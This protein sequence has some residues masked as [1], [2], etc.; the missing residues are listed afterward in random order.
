MNEERIGLVIAASDQASPTIRTVTNNINNVGRG[1]TAAGN[2]TSTAFQ[3]IAKTSMLAAAKVGM[4]AYALQKVLD[5]GLKAEKI[6]GVEKVLSM[7]EDWGHYN[8]QLEKT[9]NSLDGLV[10]RQDL[11]IPLSKSISLGMDMTGDSFSDLA[12]LVKKASL[13]MGTDYTQALNDAVE[14]MGKMSMEVINNLGVTLSVTE[15][16]ETYAKSIGRTAASLTNAEKKTAFQTVAIKKL[17]EQYDKID[18]TKVNSDLE[19]F[20]KK[21][22]DIK[23]TGGGWVAKAGTFWIKTIESAAEGVAK[24]VHPELVDDLTFKGEEAYDKLTELDKN[25]KKTLDDRYA[26]MTSSDAD[27]QVRWYNKKPM[28]DMAIERI[29]MIETQQKAWTVEAQKT[30]DAL[31]SV[32]GKSINIAE[33]MS[34]EIKD[35]GL[36]GTRVG[37]PY[38]S[39]LKAHLEKNKGRGVNIEADLERKRLAEQ[40][41]RY[42]EEVALASEKYETMKHYSHLYTEEEIREAKRSLD[43]AIEKD[44][45]KKRQLQVT[46]DVEKRELDVE[47]RELDAN[48]A[49]KKDLK[50]AEVDFEK[51]MN[52]LRLQNIK[53]YSK[54]EIDE[55]DY[56]NK[57]KLQKEKETQRQKM[58]LAQEGARFGLDMIDALISGEEDAIPKLLLMAGKS[59]GGQMIMDGIRIAMTGK[60][61]GFLG[62]PFGWSAA[63]LGAAMITT[64]T[65]MYTGASLGLNALNGGGSSGS[66]A[67]TAARENNNIGGSKDINVNVNANL[68]GSK[69]EAQLALKKMGVSVNY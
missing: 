6:R 31:D 9:V 25:F 33:A 19:K 20:N 55:E 7:K 64:G 53:M 27:W 46:L 12:V 62:N 50:V 2:Q 48:S 61:E 42:E 21:L 47:K 35:P 30:A 17:K 44:S 59:I 13:S 3:G 40:K 14:G 18:L 58:R 54:A 43:I 57:V 51:S 32:F 4:V 28:Y 67:G 22:E 37:T 29:K 41:K 68:Y 23:Q 10:N 45:F 66:N 49:R 60:A 52:E 15:A 11:L 34:K 36:G 38:Q 26:F 1:A 24:M 63:G 16:N 39:K 5:I 69:T 56:K 65:A 8:Q